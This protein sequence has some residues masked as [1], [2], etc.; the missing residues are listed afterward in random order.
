MNFL[1]FFILEFLWLTF[2][3]VNKQFIFKA[4]GNDW[5]ILKNAIHLK[6]S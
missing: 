6:L 2:L 4:F 5:V 3:I 1:F